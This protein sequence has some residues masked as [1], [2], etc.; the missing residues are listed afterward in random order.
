MINLVINLCLLCSIPSVLYN[1]VEAII[2]T[3]KSK[4]KSFMRSNEKY[5]I[6]FIF[7]ITTRHILIDRVLVERTIIKQ[8]IRKNLRKKFMINFKYHFYKLYHIPCEKMLHL[9]RRVKVHMNVQNYSRSNLMKSCMHGAV[10]EIQLDVL[11]F[12]AIF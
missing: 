2:F 5:N 3:I 11:G 1:L 6:E 12:L 9:S 4:I 10:L 7:L 8:K